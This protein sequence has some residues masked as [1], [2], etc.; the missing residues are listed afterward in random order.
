VWIWRIK[1]LFR[2]LWWKLFNR[3]YILYRGYH[4][5]LCGKWVNEWFAVPTYDS[6]GEWGDTWGMCN[7]CAGVT[8]CG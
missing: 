7:K 3:K 8:S 5:G 1:Y 6:V 4:C 2:K